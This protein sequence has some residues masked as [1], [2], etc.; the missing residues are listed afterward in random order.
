MDERD[1]LLSQ[2]YRAAEHPEPPAAL[3]ARILA[4]ARQAVAA[5]RRR[6]PWFAW[7]VPLSTAA[8]LVVGVSLILK[9]YREAPETIVDRNPARAIRTEAAAPALQPPTEAATEAAAQA[10]R[11]EVSGSLSA[12]G[13]ASGQRAPSRQARAMPS[14]ASAPA[15]PGNL[16]P[17]PAAKAVAQPFPEPAAAEPQAAER[18]LTPAPA[19]STG[20]ATSVA[21]AGRRDAAADQAPAGAAV[22]AHLQTMKMEKSKAAT[23]LDEAP[24]EM[25][26][27]IRRL[28]R[29]G[30][31]HEAR[32]LLEALRKRYPDYPLPED[33]RG[34]R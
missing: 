28:L 25:V 17:A 22:P 10:S 2:A 14:T 18:K 31:E 4:A 24:G 27:E 29:E 6:R 34:L 33:L 30:R 32:D 11:S 13:Q 15:S 9:E 26:E 3:D 12:Q 7:A 20:F 16:V 19:A 23:P 5:P 8:V 21:G 1:P